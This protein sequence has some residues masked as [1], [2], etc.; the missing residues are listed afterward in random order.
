METIANAAPAAAQID[1]INNQIKTL[2]EAG[3]D[4][5]SADSATTLANL[6]A[7]LTSLESQIPGPAQLN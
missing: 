4:T 1:S 3:G 7:R 2:E 5:D 6:K